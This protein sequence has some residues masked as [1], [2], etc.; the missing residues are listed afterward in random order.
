MAA[1]AQS[2]IVVFLL[3]WYGFFMNDTILS[4]LS[5]L[6]NLSDLSGLK[7]SP[8]FA[9]FEDGELEEILSF[10]EKQ[11]YD[12]GDF[13]VR[14]GE[15]ASAFYFLVSGR[16][17][18]IKQYGGT[19]TT[20]A[21]IEK[22]NHFGEKCLIEAAVRFASVIAAA[23]SAVIR[24]PK[25]RFRAY[26]AARPRVKEYIEQYLRDIGLINLIRLTTGFGTRIPL[27]QFK[28]LIQSLE[29]ESHAPGEIIFREG[30][31]GDR[32]YIIQEGICEVLKKN[33]GGEQIPLIKLEKGKFFGEK[34]LI[35]EKNRA[36][37]VRALTDCRLLSLSR[38]RFL[39]LYRLAPA[40]TQVFEDKLREYRRYNAHV[41][42]AKRPKIDDAISSQAVDIEKLVTTGKAAAP[43][44]SDAV[45]GFESSG[46]PIRSFPMIHQHT[47]TDCGAACLAMIC[48][49]YG[50]FVGLGHLRDMSNIT[51]DGASM[52]SLAEAAG[53]LGLAGQA[54]RMNMASLARSRLPAICHWGGYHWVA[55]YRVTER[56]VY[57]A[58]P[59]AGRVRHS[60]ADFMGQFSGNALLLRPTDA[61][62]TEPVGAT[63]LAQLPPLLF[64]H[65][66]TIAGILA[67]AL[68]LSL[69]GL[70]TPLFTQLIIDRVLGE[71]NLS[72]L[73]VMMT[74]MVV[75]FVFQ[76]LL[77]IIK[78]QLTFRAAARIDLQ[79]FGDLFDHLFRLP[80][81]FF[82][83]RRTRDLAALFNENRRL[84]SFLTGNAVNLS[85]DLFSM[86]LYLGAMCLY[87]LRL[88][89]IFLG[90]V[91][92]TLL[93]TAWMAPRARR[94]GQELDRETARQSLHLAETL[95]GMETL[96]ATAAEAHRRRLW[97]DAHER[98][99]R[100]RYR[101]FQWETAMK[102]TIR[103]LGFGATALILYVGAL[104]VVAGR[105]TP[106]QLMAFVGV[107]AAVMFPMTALLGFW[108]EIQSARGRLDRL[109]DVYNATPE[110]E[111]DP[112]SNNETG[113][114]GY[115]DSK[116]K[117][118][119]TGETDSKGAA[120]P[121]GYPDS[122]LKT[123][124]TGQPDSKVE[125]APDGAPAAAL[126]DMRGLVTFEN[127]SF[128]YGSG[129]APPILRDIGFTAYP[130]WKVAVVGRAGSGKTTLVRMINGLL[131]PE[132][133]TVRIDGIDIRRLAPRKLRERIGMAAQDGFIFSGTIYENIAL[134]R[135][136]VT[137]EK[138][139]SAAAWAEA[140][141][142]VMQ[143]P[144]GYHTII[145]EGGLPLTI[146][147][148]QR[149]CIARQLAGDPAMLIIDAAT[150][151]LDIETEKALH[152]RLGRI[153]RGGTL[154]VVAHRPAVAAD[155][156]LILALENGAIVE[157]GRHHELMD[158]QGLY[159]Y[160]NLSRME[161]N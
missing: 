51:L 127:V 133:G 128:R 147:Q 142:F 157:Q 112:D 59:A 8:F 33:A 86:T 45:A 154:F 1:P 105:M 61:F 76:T 62:T 39:Q 152:A 88:T 60:H 48:R 54:V 117:T 43:P 159:Y 149:I 160:L 84:Q 126:T 123:G 14:E 73:R 21:T 95:T 24:F 138:A 30:T 41:L 104:Q 83:T 81:L 75:L 79:L 146:G 42:N 52:R 46:P 158:R 23:D 18:V 92:F 143:F 151:A 6:S 131:R 65:R 22:G 69:M 106:G 32:F 119:P 55:V 100:L 29:R 34:A 101:H 113:L 66:R 17:K 150:D 110:P 139:M 125:T 28:T 70:A 68:A 140:H 58:D 72:L 98:L 63:T 5:D 103:S 124:P 118:G 156:D 64:A 15:E 57:M 12:F 44:L 91:A 121:K 107:A 53:K 114:K 130:G 111:G 145:G 122:K 9:F 78:S 116:V 102:T 97:R 40:V 13:I 109:G 120:E 47:I 31:P 2:M 115:P 49:H 35:E 96:K 87:S 38:E 7:E 37:T 77:N 85:I 89:G 4:D 82:K 20:L 153:M 80:L 3:K 155:A 161:I 94:L 144:V 134:G 10:A 136:A 148:R 56:H 74:G 25:D 129:D 27:K 135:P 26:I 71:R 99:I 132:S 108:D 137:L 16:V 50:K 19:E 67:C 90:F 93:I 36:A 141:D 11:R